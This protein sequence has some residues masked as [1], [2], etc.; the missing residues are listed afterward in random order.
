M[1]NKVSLFILSC[2]SIISLVTFSACSSRKESNDE[3][4]RVESSNDEEP[5]TTIS[6]SI[7]GNLSLSQISTYPNKVVLT[8]MPQHRLITVY[9]TRI[10]EK[11]STPLLRKYYEDNDSESEFEEHFM[12]GIDLIYGYNLLNVAHYDMKTENLN[13]LFQH[14]VLI[15]SLYYPS[16]VQDS[17]NKKPINRDYYLIS[18]YEEDTNRDTLINKTDLRRFY[19][20]NST[21]SEKIRLIPED[22][23]VVRSQ[24]D[25]GNDAMYLFARQDTNHD[26]MT[27]TNE[28]LHVFWFSMKVPDKAKRLY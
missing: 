26:G 13:F 7:R 11:R 15:K 12:P 21:S 6:N 8:G 25:A 20:F 28:P 10:E 4:I 14:P 3:Q 19:Y 5:D 27:G 1:Q 23:S 16:F 2:L 17:I 18:V 24:Y 22:Y 9:K